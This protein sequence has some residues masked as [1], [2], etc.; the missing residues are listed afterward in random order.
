MTLRHLLQA[1]LDRRRAA[2]R[3]YSLRRFAGQLGTDHATLSQLLRG[4]R[5]LSERG[6]RALGARLGLSEPLLS[7]CCTA[8]VDEAVLSALRH[9]RFRPD[10][11]WIAVQTNLAA[12]TV[13]IALQ[14]LLRRGA[15]RMVTPARWIVEA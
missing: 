12:D 15:L 8:A 2:N 7:A 4:R 10:S 13:N 11:R 9:P 3:R 14:R 6:V 1:E 5:R